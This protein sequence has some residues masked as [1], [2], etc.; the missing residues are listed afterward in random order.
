MERARKPAVAGMFYLG[1]SEQLKEEVN[2]FINTSDCLASQK[3]KF[4]ISPHAG[5]IYSGAIAGEV[6][7]EIKPYTY[8]HVILLGPSHRFWFGGLAE[9]DAEVWETPIG[10]SPVRSL[11]LKKMKDA[12]IYHAEEHGLEVQLP[13]LQT[14]Y[15]GEISPILVSGNIQHAA[16]YANILE[17]FDGENTLWIISSDFNHVGPTFQYSPAKY[18][19]KNGEEMDAEAIKIIESGDIQAFTDYLNTNHATICGRLPILIA[20]H[21]RQKLG[22]ANFKLKKYASSGSMTKDRNSVG[23]GALYC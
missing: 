16:E 12:S 22:I 20:M 7:A 9:S 13:F 8:D 4:I 21:L 2:S 19:F 6:F 23:Y 11:N 14:L 10:T 17:S 15:K 1:D 18:G 5:Y 3:V